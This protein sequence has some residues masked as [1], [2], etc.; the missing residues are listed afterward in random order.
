MT[1][2]IIRQCAD[3]TT[4]LHLGPAVAVQVEV[5]LTLGE[6]VVL[7]CDPCWDARWRAS[8]CASCEDDE[9]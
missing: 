4:V 7:V 5:D 3:C 9:R 1:N 2:P 6:E 8:L